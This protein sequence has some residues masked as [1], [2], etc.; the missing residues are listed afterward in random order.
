ME[1]INFYVSPII[2][3]HS[4]GI[5]IQ[6]EWNIQ[7][8][9][10]INAMILLQ[11]SLQMLNVSLKK[12]QIS[13]FKMRHLALHFLI[14]CFNKRIINSRSIFLQMIN[15]F[16]KQIQIVENLP[17]FLCKNK[18][19]KWKMILSKLASHHLKYSTRFQMFNSMTII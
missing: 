11:I 16:L 12:L 5:F 7:K 13:I 1:Q 10:C 14:Q 15:Y 6:K 2:L 18:S 8:L 4:K 9:N 3:I 17:T 19:S